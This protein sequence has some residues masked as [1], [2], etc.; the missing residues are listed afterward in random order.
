MNKRNNAIIVDEFYLDDKLNDCY[1]NDIKESIRFY[2][3]RKKS[4]S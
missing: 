2:E 1:D 3:L 4:D